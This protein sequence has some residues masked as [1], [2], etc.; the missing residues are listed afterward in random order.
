MCGTP[1]MVLVTS[2]LCDILFVSFGWYLFLCFL[3]FELFGFSYFCHI[4]TK[5][6]VGTTQ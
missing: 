2:E 6:S 4:T 3:R 5:T 1:F